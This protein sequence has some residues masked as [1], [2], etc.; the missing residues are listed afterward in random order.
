V[1]DINQER[2][3]SQFADDAG[4]DLDAK[5]YITFAKAIIAADVLNVMGYRTR[6]YEVVAGATDAA[7]SR[8]TKILHEAFAQGRSVL[9]ALRRCRALFAK[10]E[11]DRLRPKPKVAIIG[12]FWAMTTE[13]EGN[14]HLQRFL[15]SEG[16]ECEVSPVTIWGFYNIWCAEYDIRE[17]M[18]LRRRT[19]D[20]HPRENKNSVSTLLLLRVAA[21]L[22]RRWF[23]TYAWTIGLEGYDL[24][25][26]DELASVSHRF[27]PNEL[28]GGEGHLEI[29]EVLTTTAKEKS[30]L[31][32]SIKPF[33]CMPSSAI[34][35]GIQTIVNAR[36]PEVNFLTVETT[37]DGAVSVYSRVQMALFKARAKAHA[38]FEAALISRGLTTKQAARRTRRLRRLT[39]ATHYPRHMKAATAAN[40]VCEL[41]PYHG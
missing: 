18:M 12:E 40:A 24:P 14:Y 34:S 33:G 31:A 36:H 30:H 8:A 27:Y 38:E 22:L 19:Q 35:D 39:R 25:S 17:R 9:L 16:A 1:L 26:M 20:A 28:R 37:G 21:W 11:V 4:I 10:I 32:I 29:G 5:S 3:P 2:G 6:P 7:L 41:S 23:D 15:E 13:G